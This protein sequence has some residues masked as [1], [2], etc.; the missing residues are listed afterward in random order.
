MIDKANIENIATDL[1]NKHIKRGSSAKA[2]LKIISAEGVQFREIDATE[3]FWGAFTKSPTGIPYIIINKAI[4]NLG[5]KHFTIAHELGHY[6]LKHDLHA[7]SFL[8]GEKE[9]KEDDEITSEQEKEANYFASCFLLP[10]ERLI[11]KFTS[12]FSW[13]MKGN[14]DIPLIVYPKGKYYYNWKIIS[15]KLMKDFLVSE[16]ALRIRLINLGLIKWHC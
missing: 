4:Q 6:I 8:C 16:M 10:K 3:A 7:V 2:I 1:F 14:S 13:Q 9:I 15:S 11:K 12:Y 5:R